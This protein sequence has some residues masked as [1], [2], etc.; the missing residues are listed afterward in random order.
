MSRIRRHNGG[1]EDPSRG[2][3]R[4]TN[5]AQ[6]GGVEPAAG[7]LPSRQLLTAARVEPTAT[8]TACGQ[9]AFLRAIANLNRAAHAMLLPLRHP[10]S[11]RPRPRLHSP[12]ACRKPQTHR[13]AAGLCRRNARRRQQDAKPAAGACQC[14]PKFRRDAALQAAC[15][16]STA[17]LG[18]VRLPGRRAGVDG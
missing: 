6:P 17:G 14:S 12:C 1:G 7:A 4:A 2:Q 5:A 3:L 13:R 9:K 18:W 8:P 15:D 10:P 16:R 11:T